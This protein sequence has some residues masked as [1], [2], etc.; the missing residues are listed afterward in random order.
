MS[1][2]STS[3]GSITGG[4]GY[5][6]ALARFVSNLISPPLVGIITAVA[7]IYHTVP[8]PQAVLFWLS[9]ALPILC[10]PPLAYVVWL[11]RIGELAD[12]HMPDRRSRIKPLSVILGWSIAALLAL[13]ILGA[14]AVLIMVM[15]AT[16]GYMMLMSAVTL[17]WKISFHSSAIA[18]AASIGIVA[19]GITTSWSI[20][21]LMLIPLVGWA[22]VSLRR[23]TL[24]Q[25]LA[26]CAAGMGMGLFLLI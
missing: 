7:F 17:F 15:I 1:F 26:G 10:L 16:M 2:L 22:R 3:R 18:A 24:G 6:I 12:I 14:P 20:V 9:W 5:E 19:G 25:V 4:L 23:H 21:A 8:Q 13:H 11:V